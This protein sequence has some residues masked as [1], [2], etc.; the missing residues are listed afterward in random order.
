M[1]AWAFS[2][3]LGLASLGCT[4]VPVDPYEVPVG[5]LTGKPRAEVDAILADVAA[6]VDLDADDV[7]S[8][9]EI[10]DFL[11]SEMPF[12]AAILRELNRGT[13]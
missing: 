5:D 9:P 3:G 4:A 6:R 2:A 7:R 12:T 1:R 13:W 11:L 8:R 10:Y